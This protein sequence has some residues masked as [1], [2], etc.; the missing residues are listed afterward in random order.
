MPLALAAPTAAMSARLTNK[1]YL[2][3]AL[4]AQQLPA[5][6]ADMSTVPRLL[7]PDEWND[8]AARLQEYVTAI[9]ATARVFDT[10]NHKVE[11]LAAY[12]MYMVWIDAWAKLSGFGAYVDV[13]TE[14]STSGVERSQL[15]RPV[16]GGR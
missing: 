3:T 7:P 6:L 8:E 10:Y 11:T 14:V 9:R 15:E 2:P 16:A 1:K 4:I 13:D 5:G 12:D